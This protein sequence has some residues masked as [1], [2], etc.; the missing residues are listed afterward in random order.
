MSFQLASIDTSGQTRERIVDKELLRQWRK[1]V[2]QRL[3]VRQYTQPRKRPIR[4]AGID[5]QGLRCMRANRNADQAMAF[6]GFIRVS[7]P[8]SIIPR[9]RNS[10]NSGASITEPIISLRVMYLKE[11]KMPH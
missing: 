2:A 7:I 4:K 10:S 1:M 11:L 9:Q 6:Q 8:R 5:C 3:C